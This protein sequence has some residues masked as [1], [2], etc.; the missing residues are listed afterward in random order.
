M[1]GVEGGSF[2]YEGVRRYGS[3]ESVYFDERVR[4]Q[5]KID[6]LRTMF[7][8]ANVVLVDW[9]R[10]G[11]DGGS[12]E[13]KGMND[14]GVYD[15]RR[16]EK[17]GVDDAGN[18][19]IKQGEVI[20]SER[21]SPQTAPAELGVMESDGGAVFGCESE[22]KPRP[23]SPPPRRYFLLKEQLPSGGVGMEILLRCYES[24]FNRDESQDIPASKI[25]DGTESRQQP[26]RPTSATG[27]P[28]ADDGV[29]HQDGIQSK[30]PVKTR[31]TPPSKRTFSSKPPTPIHFAN[32]NHNGSHNPDDPT[33]KRDD[34]NINSNTILNLNIDSTSKP[35][36]P[37]PLITVTDWQ[38]EDAAT[39]HF[40]K[41]HYQ[42]HHPHH[43]QSQQ[44][45]TVAPKTNDQ[46]LNEII[47]ENHNYN[48]KLITNSGRSDA[49]SSPIRVSLNFNS[50]EM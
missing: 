7:D 31:T 3:H 37:T 16:Q 21:R 29:L 23:P 22:P 41:Q 6:P 36:T 45:T 14:N 8:K 33:T 11:G 26:P 46:L 15:R 1:G 5:H 30:P 48:E 4:K 40:D 17:V 42:H 20:E 19:S 43:R 18:N 38:Q 44:M 2:A 9:G 47:D 25:D 12:C 49:G 13:R 39:N 32:V 10:K 28:F 35:P 50:V 24:S 34:F 27:V